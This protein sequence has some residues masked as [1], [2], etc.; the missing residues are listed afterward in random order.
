MAGVKGRR[1]TLVRLLGIQASWSYERMQG[2]GLGHAAEPMLRT[3]CPE[4]DRYR[5]GL[6]RAAGFFNANPYLAAAAV[7]AEVRAE[8]DGLPAEQIDRLRVALSGPLGSLG[9][10]L[11]W[12]GLV[13]AMASLT[14]VLVVLGLGPWPAIG[15]VVAHNLVRWR[16][17]VRLLAMGWDHGVGI[18]AAIR[19]SS[20]QRWSVVTG[21]AAALLGGLAIPL[22]AARFLRGSP[23]GALAG[24]LA[25]VLGA[26]LLRHLAG[27]RVSALPLTL[28]AAG[29][30]LLWQWGSA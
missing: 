19:K 2:V 10:R 5:K 18:G 23:P 29:L 11:F 8:H 3:V 27:P 7:G 28:A 30:V 12:T 15:F 25:L 21:G 24:V 6:A 4:P 22:V 13:P 9:D 17:G 14:V 16:V 1:R 26:L 20:L